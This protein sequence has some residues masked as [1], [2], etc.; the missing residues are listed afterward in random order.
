MRLMRGGRGRKSVHSRARPP[1]ALRRCYSGEPGGQ[2]GSWSTS[3]ADGV[4]TWLPN[5][6][7]ADLPEYDE[8]RVVQC[9]LKASAA[10]SAA[11]QPVW[12]V[13]T[14]G[15]AM[16]A[17][18]DCLTG[19]SRECTGIAETLKDMGYARLVFGDDPAS[20][21]S[22]RGGDYDTV[23]WPPKQEGKEASSQ[24]LPALRLS[25]RRL[26]AHRAEFLH[27]KSM[28]WDVMRRADGSLRKSEN[29]LARRAPSTWGKHPSALLFSTGES[30]VP[31]GKSAADKN[32]SSAKSAV[33][34]LRESYAEVD[35]QLLWVSVGTPR[36]G[37]AERASPTTQECLWDRECGRMRA[38]HHRLPFVDV[39]AMTEAAWR[40]HDERLAIKVEQGLP[41]HREVLRRWMPQLCHDLPQIPEK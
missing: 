38:K 19:A 20:P 2:R 29:W 37:G 23:F 30:F 40:S 1:A 35:K 13:V 36:P 39:A 27:P 34:F 15:D 32:C 31:A 8:N 24:K 18:Y 10:T 5:M 41:L 21:S 9:I 22:G 11:F 3:G 12:L 7:C 6:R 16:R 33:A 28:R 26:A 14:G 25:Y 17:T 4:P